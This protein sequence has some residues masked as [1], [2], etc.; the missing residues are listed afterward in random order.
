MRFY[1]D[2]VGYLQN[3][4]NNE[5]TKIC[6]EKHGQKFGTNVGGAI[7][8]PLLTTCQSF[9]RFGPCDWFSQFW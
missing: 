5:L 9:C 3:N 2:D 4:A 8:R 7:T 6:D 1:Q